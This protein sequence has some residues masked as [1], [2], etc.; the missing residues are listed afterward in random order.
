MA[1]VKPFTVVSTFAGCGGSSLGYKLAGGSVR[2]AVEWDDGAAS[3]YRRNHPTTD[4]FHGDIAALTVDDALARIGMKPG[5][6]D[7]FDGS[8]PCQGFSMAGRRNIEDQRNQLF[9][10][11]VRLLRGLQP[12]AFVMENVGG[13]VVGKM[14]LIFAEI[15]REL[16]AS[17]Y[18]V[19]A[20]KLIA[21]DYGVPQ[22]RVRM[23]FIGAREDLGIDP[24][25]PAPTHAPVSAQ[26]ALVGL[27][28]DE[29]EVARLLEIGK[30]RKAYSMWQF[31]RPGQNLTRIGLKSGFNTVK[32]NPMRPCP[33][34]TKS[35]AYL[36]LGGLMHWAEQRPF[37]VAELKRFSTFPDDFD[38]GDDYTNAVERIGNTVPPLL[39]KAVA[40][41]VRT[42]ILEA[43][44]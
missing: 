17:G 23:I 33:T 6:L 18:R 9:R 43:A 42:T 29:A 35:T 32:V 41:H 36:G 2:L 7:I 15:L 12:R 39:M 21:S 10:E 24:T 5:E 8:P 44:R 30:S 26:Q 25:H 1:E 3:I 40:E 20:R 31:M 4:L 38:F 11:Y 13:M 16:K 27:E 34:I 37:T 22:A 28:Q 19:A 14:R